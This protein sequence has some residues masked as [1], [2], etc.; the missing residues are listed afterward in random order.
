MFT[1]LPPSGDLYT[2]YFWID[3][4]GE[5]KTPRGSR[6]KQERKG[7][8]CL[9]GQFNPVITPFHGLSSAINP[10]CL[11]NINKTSKFL[12]TLIHYLLIASVTADFIY[13]TYNYWNIAQKVWELSVCN[14]SE[15]EGVQ[16]EVFKPSLCESKVACEQKSSFSK[17]T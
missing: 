6:R 7:E 8:A 5:Q 10:S 1:I 15:F 11:Q 16:G 4:K 14:N 3:Y 12:T 17:T 2:K 9:F 13:P